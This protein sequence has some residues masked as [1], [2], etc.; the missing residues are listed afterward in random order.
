MGGFTPGGREDAGVLP[1]KG[2]RLRDHSQEERGGVRCHPQEV[3]GARGMTP[4]YCQDRGVTLGFLQE[5]GTVVGVA[6][7]KGVTPDSRSPH[8]PQVSVSPASV[9]VPPPAEPSGSEGETARP[10][11]A[12]QSCRGEISRLP[13][14][15]LLPGLR[16]RDFLSRCSSLALF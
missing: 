11:R 8:P 7:R 14:P 9:R 10:S 3:G 16:V 2:G 6:L 1:G 4:G 5:S 12:S 13:S 15:R